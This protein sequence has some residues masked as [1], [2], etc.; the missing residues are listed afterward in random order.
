MEPHLPLFPLSSSRTAG[1]APRLL[2]L[3]RAPQPALAARPTHQAAP[4]LHLLLLSPFV[5][6]CSRSLPRYTPRR[7]ASRTR[8]PPAARA[9]APGHSVL[10]S[11]PVPLPAMRLPPFRRSPPAAVPRC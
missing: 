4:S 1:P 8:P 10:A 11:A 3:S 7:V 2:A 6:P 9:C 5:P